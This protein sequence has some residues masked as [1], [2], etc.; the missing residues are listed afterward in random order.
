VADWTDVLPDGLYRCVQALTPMGRSQPLAST[1]SEHTRGDSKMPPHRGEGSNSLV[2]RP[3][4]LLILLV[5]SIVRS[6]WK[7]R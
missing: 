2:L 3:L 4:I 1:A 6:L 7:L 5:I